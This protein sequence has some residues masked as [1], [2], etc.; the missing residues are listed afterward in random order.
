VRRMS[1]LA[2]KPDPVQGTAASA[3]LPSAI[4]SDAA[5]TIA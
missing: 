4:A 3:T 5:V 2:P 1:R